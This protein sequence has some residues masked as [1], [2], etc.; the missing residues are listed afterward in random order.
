MAFGAIQQRAFDFDQAAQPEPEQVAEATSLPP[1]SSSRP[2]VRPNRQLV[3]GGASHYEWPAPEHD[4]DTITV[5]R[6]R[7]DIDGP[8]RRF[9]IRRG[10]AVV[11]LRR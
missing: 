1:P 2:L 10:D 4:R 11:Q 3:Y 5:D 6:I 8:S 7:G 9:V